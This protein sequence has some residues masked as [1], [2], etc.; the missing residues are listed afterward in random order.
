MDPAVQGAH[1]SVGTR[2]KTMLIP[3]LTDRKALYRMEE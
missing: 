1:L 3:I 2:I